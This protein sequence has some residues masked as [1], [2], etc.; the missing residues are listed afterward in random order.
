MLKQLIKDLAIEQLALKKARKTGT[1]VGTFTSWDTNV[2]EVL[3]KSWVAAYQV[4]NNRLRITAALNLYHEQRGSGHRHGVQE[5]DKYAYE[6]HFK[7][8]GSLLAAK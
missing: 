4:Y 6:F 5:S 2:P 7:E 8:L 3:K 1:I